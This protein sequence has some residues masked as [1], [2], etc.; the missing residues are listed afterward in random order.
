M[1]L[2]LPWKGLQ[3]HVQ[4]TF[5]EDLPKTGEIFEALDA[6]E[7]SESGWVTAKE[8]YG[9]LFFNEYN[10]RTVLKVGAFCGVTQVY[11]HLLNVEK[12]LGRDATFDLMEAISP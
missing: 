8:A 5:K 6:T 4:L 1:Q 10:G 7:G 2:T 11:Y 12:Q 3:K 9:P